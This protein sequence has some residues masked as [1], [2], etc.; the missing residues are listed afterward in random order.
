MPWRAGPYFVGGQPHRSH[1]A[2][3]EGLSSD[4]LAQFTAKRKAQVGD[5]RRRVL[6]GNSLLK[7]REVNPYEGSGSEVKSGFFQRFAR[8]L[9]PGFRRGRGDRPGC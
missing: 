5:V 4:M 1:N 6:S 7:T 8:S 3:V 9:A 2:F